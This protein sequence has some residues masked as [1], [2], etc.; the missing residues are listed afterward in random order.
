MPSSAAGPAL[1]LSAIASPE[2]ALALFDRLQ[3][4]RI[5]E[6]LG[7]WRGGSV[8][9]GHPLDGLLKRYH[10]YGKTFRGPDDV[11]SLLFHTSGDAVVPPRTRA[12]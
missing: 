12:A 2:E 7:R 3:V 1:P 4:V 8:A 11:D 10:W 9:T 6:L 5:S